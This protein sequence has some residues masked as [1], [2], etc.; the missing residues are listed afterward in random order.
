MRWNRQQQHP[1]KTSILMSKKEITS[2]DDLK[3]Q[4][5]KYLEKRKEVNADQVAQATKGKIVGGT[6]GNPVLEYVSA[7][8]VREQIIEQAPNVFDYDE[9]SKYGFSHLVTPIMKL[10]GG[11]RA[12]YDMM[13]LDPPPLIGP[14]PKKNAPELKID[15]TGEEDKARYSGLKMGQVLDDSTMAEAL[16][17]ANQRAKE[18]KELRPR[19][20]EELYVRPFAGRWVRF[21]E[22]GCLEKTDSFGSAC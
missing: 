16:D 19:L 21:C 10:N 2:E 6:R 11:R 14:P 22:D 20:M 5:S 18:G 3:Q 8:P 17:R 1:S 12:V 7:A 13:G 15:R 4:L 9:L